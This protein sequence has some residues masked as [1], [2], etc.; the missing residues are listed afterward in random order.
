[1]PT[2]VEPAARAANASPCSM[3][4][5]IETGP[6]SSGRPVSQPLTPGPQRR[7]AALVKYMMSGVRVSLARN[8]K[9]GACPL[10]FCEQLLREPGEFTRQSGVVLARGGTGEPGVD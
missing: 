2:R 10:F 7:P 3:Q 6:A 9:I 5:K 8:R 1:M 4:T